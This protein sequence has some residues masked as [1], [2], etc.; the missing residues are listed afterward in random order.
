DESLGFMLRLKS[1]LPQSARRRI[2]CSSEHSKVCIELLD[3]FRVTP[4][5]LALTGTIAPPKSGD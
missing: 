2:L 1:V 5:S 3:T 4:E